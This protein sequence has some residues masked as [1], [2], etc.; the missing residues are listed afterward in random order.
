MLHE[1]LRALQSHP[2]R[3]E[4]L[5]REV[6]QVAGDPVAV[7][8]QSHLLGVPAPVGQLQRQGRL[9][10]EAGQGRDL[11]RC[12]RRRPVRLASIST[13]AASPWYPP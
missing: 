6:M 7:R 2:R 4:P 11:G 12:E 13:P 8:E 3:E 10:G 5:D 1:A 9:P